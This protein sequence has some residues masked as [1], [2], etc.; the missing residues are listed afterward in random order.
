MADSQDDFSGNDKHFK[1]LRNA[2]SE[3]DISIW[4]AFSASMGPRFRA[5]LRGINLAGQDLSGAKLVGA[6]L[7]GACLDGANLTGADLTGASL[8][9]A[10]LRD[11]KLDGTPKLKNKVVVRSKT[12]VS[13]E[14]QDPDT[15]RRIKI[16]RMQEQARDFLVDKAKKEAALE[17]QKAHVKARNNPSP[18]SN[19]SDR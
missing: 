19:D 13:T 5:D 3:K 7:D 1:V 9:G 6:R 14:P 18:F 4:N 2:L 12:A 15:R 8:T 11:A 10:S 17:R 16:E